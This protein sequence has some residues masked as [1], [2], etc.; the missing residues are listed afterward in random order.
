[1]NKKGQNIN[2]SNPNQILSVFV[3][4]ILLII[5]MAY[6][7]YFINQTTCSD[8]IEK[9]GN[10]ENQLNNCN[11]NFALMNESVAKCDE[12]IK[13]AINSCNDKIENATKECNTTKE[14]YY[15]FIILNKY[16]YITYTLSLIIWLSLTFLFLKKI[17]KPYAK[18]T[19]PITTFGIA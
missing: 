7:P 11:Q 16:I 19:M 15:N 14:D 5:F 13:T 8:E 1:M 9:I 3:G 4:I 6:L 2:W 12:K 18:E 10:L 17:P